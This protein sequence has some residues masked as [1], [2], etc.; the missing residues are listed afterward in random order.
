MTHCGSIRTRSLEIKKI[1]KYEKGEQ[2][3]K[4][5][6]KVKDT[7]LRYSHVGIHIEISASYV[8]R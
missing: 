4:N 7:V 1:V 3:R 8:K 6:K 5:M 2:L